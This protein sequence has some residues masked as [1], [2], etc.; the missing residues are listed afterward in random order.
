MKYIAK[1]ER[2]LL[3]LKIAFTC[4]F[5]KKRNKFSHKKFG[6]SGINYKWKKDVKNN[7]ALFGCY[8][9]KHL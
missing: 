7:M 9:I 3:S 8:D 2:K 4:N 6:W 5:F 1:Q